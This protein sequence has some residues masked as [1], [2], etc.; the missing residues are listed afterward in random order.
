MNRYLATAA[1]GLLALT[2]TLAWA[3]PAAA[4]KS[5]EP[6]APAVKTA[7]PAPASDAKANDCGKQMGHKKKAKHKAMAKA[8]KKDPKQAKA[9][10]HKAN[11]CQDVPKPATKA[12]SKPP[13]KPATTTPPR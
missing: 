13:A 1:G 2:V 4:P 3:A 10:K 11:P 8:G 7:A 12:A 9:H 6:K 5:A